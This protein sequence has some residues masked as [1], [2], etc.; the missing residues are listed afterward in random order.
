MVIVVVAVGTPT[1]TCTVTGCPEA[2]DSWIGREGNL[3]NSENPDDGL[4]IQRSGITDGV[5]IT[6]ICILAGV[7]S[8]D[9]TMHSESL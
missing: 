2:G 5:A 9:V 7:K 6:G 3:K 8:V 4:S 1:V